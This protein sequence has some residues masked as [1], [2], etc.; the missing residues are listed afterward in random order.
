MCN[1]GCV[2]DGFS[3]TE[4]ERGWVK[5]IQVYIVLFCTSVGA[6]R[7]HFS[8][9]SAPPELQSLHSGQ[10]L[11]N[12]GKFLQNCKMVVSMEGSLAVSAKW[13]KHLPFDPEIPLLEVASKDSVKKYKNDVC[14]RLFI[15]LL[16]VIVED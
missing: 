9:R 12:T 13:H 11:G 2:C 7:Y 10:V 6:G 8:V 15:V 3:H 16:F 1:W 14:M 4:R 5:C